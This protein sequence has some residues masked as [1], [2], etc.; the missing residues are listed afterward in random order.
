M[1]K[2]IAVSFVCSLAALVATSEAAASP[3]KELYGK[4]IPYFG[5]NPAL[6]KSA[7]DYKTLKS[8]YTSARRG[9]FSVDCAWKPRAAGSVVR[10]YLVRAR[11]RSKARELEERKSAAPNSQPIR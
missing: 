4:S 8:T 6:K 3:P 1:S 11:R 9:A 7:A 10:G 5:S 2:S